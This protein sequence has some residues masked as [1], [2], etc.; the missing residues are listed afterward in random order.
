MKYYRIDWHVPPLL[1]TVLMKYLTNCHFRLNIKVAVI[2]CNQVVRNCNQIWNIVKPWI[3]GN[4][5]LASWSWNS[6]EFQQAFESSEVFCQ[7]KGLSLP[8]KFVQLLHFNGWYVQ[9]QESG[10]SESW[11]TLICFFPRLSVGSWGKNIRG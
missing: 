1:F 9:N 7:L 6:L 2:N 5:G 3:V 4:R 8:F 10:S 11:E